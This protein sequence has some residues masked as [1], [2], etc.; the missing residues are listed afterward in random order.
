MMADLPV[1]PLAPHSDQSRR[2]WY[3]PEDILDPIQVKPGLICADLGCGAGEFTYL[4]ARRVGADGRVYAVDPSVAA[5]DQLKIK[6][7]GVNIVTLRA[8][9]TETHLA[10]ACCDLVLLSFSLSTAPD[11]GGVLAE[12]ARLL[13]PDG[14]LAVV[15]WRPVPPPPGPPLD[16]RIRSDRMQRMIESHGFVAVQRLREGAVF[17]TLVAQKGKPGPAQPAR[18]LPARPSV[19]PPRR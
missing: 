13:K 16:R 10:L 7:P 2:T 4:L 17:Y 19:R 1:R 6:K 15:D 14:R 3:D 18:P 5:L 8:D 11:A 12:A 9:L